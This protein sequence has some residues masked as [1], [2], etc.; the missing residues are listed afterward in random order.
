[1]VGGGRRG[2]EK[3]RS[4]SLHRSQTGLIRRKFSYTDVN[5]LK[6]KSGFLRLPVP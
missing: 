4:V 3:E 6:E 5:R 1:M 2:L